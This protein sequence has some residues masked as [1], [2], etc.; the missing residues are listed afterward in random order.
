[1]SQPKPTTLAA[2]AI[3]SLAALVAAPFPEAFWTALLAAGTGLAAWRLWGDKLAWAPALLVAL[4]PSSYLLSL[5]H[6][7]VALLLWVP[8]WAPRLGPLAPLAGAL[9]WPPL[10]VAA[11]AWS[12]LAAAIALLVVPLTQLL[13]HGGSPLLAAALAGAIVAAGAVGQYLRGLPR[14]RATEQGSRQVTVLAASLVPL[15][16]AFLAA[17]LLAETTGL[18]GPRQMLLGLALGA[19]ATVVIATLHAI[20]VQLRAGRDHAPATQ[21]L[22]LMAVSGLGALGDTLDVG[23]LLALA[24]VA[25]APLVVPLATRLQAPL[26]PWAAHPTALSVVAALALAGRGLPGAPW[27]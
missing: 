13:V 17:P 11:A 6:A 23:A 12:P 16:A 7:A 2:I 20:T 26:P 10:G 14:T 24:W 9:V 27:P 8:F 15:A 25:A 21:A 4:G 3:A 19:L 5:P 18:T 1:M 22:A